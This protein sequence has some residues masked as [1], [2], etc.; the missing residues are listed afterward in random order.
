MQ[1]PSRSQSLARLDW[2]DVTAGNWVVGSN[3][4]LAAQHPAQ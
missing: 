3:V 1:L 4:G 2:Q